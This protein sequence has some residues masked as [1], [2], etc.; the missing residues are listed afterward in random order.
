MRQVSELTR[1]L[2]LRTDDGLFA[3]GPRAPRGLFRVVVRSVAPSPD[4]RTALHRLEEAAE[5]LPGM[6]AVAVRTTDPLVEVEIDVRQL[7]D[8]DHVAAELVAIVV[9]RLLSWLAGQRIA[10][11][12]LLLPWPKPDHA[13]HY[14]AIFGRHPQFDADSLILAFDRGLLP[15]PVIR[16]EAELAE[17]LDDQPDAWLA[18]RD[19][20]STHADQVRAI[21]E[22]GTT[23]PDGSGSAPST[24]AGC[25]A[26]RRRRSAKSETQSAAAP[27]SRASAAATNPSKSWP[28]A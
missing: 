11:R 12:E 13:P 8:P 6:P 2:W 27:R 21:V 15:A 14:E 23:A 18:T 20:G 17:F 9:H 24:C 28:A 22:Q 16:S 3:L 1:E 4:L 26:R 10:L 7:D 25:C 19:Y 5:V